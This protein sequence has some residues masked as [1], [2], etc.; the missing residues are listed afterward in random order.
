ML[1]ERF[2]GFTSEMLM[3]PV[4]E[5]A[6]RQRPLRLDDRPLAVQPAR[7]DRVEPGA[8]HRQPTHQDPDPPVRFTVRL[9]VPI[10]ACTARLTGSVRARAN[11]YRL[12]WDE[13]IRG[14]AACKMAST[15]T[16]SGDRRVHA[17]D[18]G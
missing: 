12:S 14:H 6:G 10:H 4:H 17:G 13:P 9:C 1:V 5:L 2:Q 7:L 8:L 11:K 18:G 15:V 16:V 3:H